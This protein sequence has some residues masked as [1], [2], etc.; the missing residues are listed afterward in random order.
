M[1]MCLSELLYLR[2]SAT[3][4]HVKAET[5]NDG[6]ARLRTLLTSLAIIIWSR[7]RSWPRRHIITINL[8]EVARR[9][10]RTVRSV[11]L[12]YLRTSCDRWSTCQNEQLRKRVWKP[13]TTVIHTM[14][15]RTMYNF[16][17]S[18]HPLLLNSI[19]AVTGSHSID[20][21]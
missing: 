19:K 2:H 20:S 8:I 4:G 15:Q 21:V 18:P 9:I 7:R 13:S 6:F 5:G 10:K 1:F 17:Y 12:S 3:D 11:R 14:I 16:N